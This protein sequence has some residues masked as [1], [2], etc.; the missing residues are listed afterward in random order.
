MRDALST[1]SAARIAILRVRMEF[2]IVFAML[3]AADFCNELSF[4]IGWYDL[5]LASAGML[6]LTGPS[7]FLG[8]ERPSPYATSFAKPLSTCR[9]R[10]SILS[11][12]ADRKSTRLNS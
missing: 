5:G 8:T 7:I 9:R 2:L 12:M 1:P 3:N 4:L 11:R 10:K 6:W